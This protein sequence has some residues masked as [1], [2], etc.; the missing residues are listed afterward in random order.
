MLDARDRPAHTFLLGIDTGGTYTDAVIW[1]ESR[2]VVAKAKSLTTRHDLSVG[3]AGAVDGALRE[4]GVAAAAIGLVSMSTTLATNALVEG[5][6]D[7]VALAMIGFTPADLARAGL[8]GAVAGSPVIF[9]PGG[10]DAHGVEHPLDLGPLEAALPELKESVSAIAICALFAVRNPRHEIAARDLIHERS[11]LPTTA[12]HELSAKLGGPKRALTTLLN[13]RLISMIGRLVETTEIFLQ[14]R[15]VSAPLMVVRGDGALVAAAFAKARPIETILSGPAA[16][17]IGARYLTGQ[18]N[19][20]VSDIGGTTTDVAVLNEGRPRLD[21][22]GARVGGFRT[23]VEAVA[24]HTFGLGGDSEVAWELHALS[25]RLKIGPRRL[26]PLSL[27][28]ALHGTAI[29][30]PLNRQMRAA[31]PREDFGRFALRT[32][33]PSSLAAGLDPNAAAL[34][35]RLDSRPQPLD[36]M[37]ESSRHHP[38][39]KRLVARG[40]AQIVGFTPSDAAHA[41]GRQSNWNAEAARLG[42][43]LFWRQKSRRG[44]AV[45]ASADALCEQ[46]LM[47]VTRLSAEAILETAFNEDGLDGA[48]S[49]AHSLVQRAMTGAKGVAR[50]DV[51]LD[52]PVIGVGASASL[53]YAGLPALLGAP[54]LTPADADVANALGAVVGQVRMRA[55]AVVLQP[56]EGRFRVSAGEYVREFGDEAAALDFAEAQVR[57][58]AAKRARMAGADNAEIAIER[59]LRAVEVG[60]RRLFISAT[61]AAVASGRPRVSL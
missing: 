18:D 16:S 6:G 37:I 39:L 41:L 51:A 2:G 29:L 38:A 45:A 4:S 46:V 47:T 10:C 1:S 26:T 32:G 60:G 25:E 30:E 24:I 55:E 40:L 54:C 33:L 13:A 61:I 28:A 20:I 23:M 31:Q 7:R 34:Y 56:V 8:N 57:K 19:A 17:L 36:Q 43:E 14:T 3:I 52:R 27:A 11:G 50:V 5:Q 48:A 12:S 53:H 22:E 9:C 15:G 58:E 49:V 21:P 59:D 42:V 44:H 35:A